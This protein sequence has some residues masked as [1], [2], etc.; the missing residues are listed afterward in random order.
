MMRRR[1][2]A[3]RSSMIR[4]GTADGARTERADA[5]R[6]RSGAPAPG[7]V[8]SRP[9]SKNERRGGGEY[10][11]GTRQAPRRPAGPIMAP[12]PASGELLGAVDPRWLMVGFA[13]LGVAVYVL[14]NPARQNIYNHFVWQADA[15]LQG[16][17]WIPW[18]L[19]DGRLPERLLPGRLPGSA[20]AAP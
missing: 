4:A 6:L 14:S 2:S 13:V 8:N 7:V 10:S 15:F 12:S 11:N 5:P 9:A 3:A 16:R 17:A 1:A 20:R 19:I 18:P